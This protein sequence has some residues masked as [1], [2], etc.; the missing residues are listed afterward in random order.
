MIYIWLGRNIL[1]LSLQL[2]RLVLNKVQTINIL[3][4]GRQ[5]GDRWLPYTYSDPIR[6]V[7]WLIRQVLQWGLSIK[8]T[9]NEG[10]LFNEDTDSA[11]STT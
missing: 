11:V 8:D 9:L 10:N 4:Q 5:I 6:Q 1:A 2:Q 7:I 3:F